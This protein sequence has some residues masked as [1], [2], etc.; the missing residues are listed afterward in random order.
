[1]ADTG[2]LTSLIDSVK[3][4]VVVHSRN[5]SHCSMAVSSLVSHA[6][7][8]IQSIHFKAVGYVVYCWSGTGTLQL[9]CAILIRKWLSRLTLQ[10][11]RSTLQGMQLLGRPSSRRSRAPRTKVADGCCVRR[12]VTLLERAWVLLTLHT[13][14]VRLR[15]PATEAPRLGHCDQ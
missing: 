10:W 5:M 2:M 6:D 11:G 12:L 15:Q 3:S 14:D 4:H 13:L 7:G 9:T 1:M 8:I